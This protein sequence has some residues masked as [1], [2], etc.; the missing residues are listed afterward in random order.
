MQDND[1][2]GKCV[3][4]YHKYTSVYQKSITSDSQNYHQPKGAGDKLVIKNA[5]DPTSLTRYCRW[6]R[7]DELLNG[8]TFTTLGE[9]KVWRQEYNQVRPHSALGDNPSAPEPLTATTL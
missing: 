4:F 8:E 3:V 1:L 9:E 5:C 6:E 7:R 2:G